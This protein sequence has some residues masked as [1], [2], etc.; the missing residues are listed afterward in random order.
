M[1]GYVPLSEQ[2]GTIIETEEELENSLNNG[3]RAVL[4]V[5]PYHTQ[6]NG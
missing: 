4:I 6:L 2:Y 3:E 5:H 1:N